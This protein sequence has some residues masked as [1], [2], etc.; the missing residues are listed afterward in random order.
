M[1]NAQ[2][3]SLIQSHEDPNTERI[4]SLVADGHTWDE[5]GEIDALE[6]RE[7]ILLERGA[8]GDLDEEQRDELAG[9]QQRLHALVGNDNER[10]AGT[11]FSGDGQETGTPTLATRKNPTCP[12]CGGEGSAEVSHACGTDTHVCVWCRGAGTLTPPRMDLPFLRIK[13]VIPLAGG[14]WRVSY[15]VRCYSSESDGFWRLQ[16]PLVKGRGDIYK[17]LWDAHEEAA[18]RFQAEAQQH[19]QRKAN[20]LDHAQRLHEESK[21]DAAKHRAFIEAQGHD[22]EVY[23]GIRQ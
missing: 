3:T 4:R 9:L 7:A 18:R 10:F 15:H 13:S 11:S 6:R 21:R 17:A 20:R 8:R 2:A 16:G 1:T 22:W 12:Q 14:V 23:A 19:A 5:A